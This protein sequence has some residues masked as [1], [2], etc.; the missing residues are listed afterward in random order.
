M[1]VPFQQEEVYFEVFKQ[2]ASTLMITGGD[3]TKLY[4]KKKAFFF[5]FFFK[6]REATFSE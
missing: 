5:L 2:W 6:Y 4:Q 1:L 3:E